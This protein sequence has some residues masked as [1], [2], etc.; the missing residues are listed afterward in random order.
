MELPDG[1]EIE[2]AST[3]AWL[4]EDLP[5]RAIDSPSELDAVLNMI[6]CRAQYPGVDIARTNFSS[7]H[8]RDNTVAFVRQLGF[9]LYTF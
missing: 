6:A 5:N 2:R 8:R 1:W 3:F 9:H 4:M 7:P